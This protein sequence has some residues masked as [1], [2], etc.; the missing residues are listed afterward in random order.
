[1]PSEGATL[2]DGKIEVDNDDN[3]SDVESRDGS[4]KV[5]NNGS[6]SD[7]AEDPDISSDVDGLYDSAPPETPSKS[8]RKPT[9]KPTAKSTGEKVAKKEPTELVRL[10]HGISEGYDA[11]AINTARDS[12]VDLL[13]AIHQREVHI[14]VNNQDKLL[15]FSEADVISMANFFFFDMLGTPARK[16]F[17]QIIKQY[18]TLG[19]DGLDMGVAARAATLARD[20]ARLPQL[21]DFYTTF[22]RSQARHKALKTTSTYEMLMKQV[23]DVEMY[24]AYIALRELG[25]DNDVTLVEFLAAAGLTISKGRGHVSIINEYLCQEL[26]IAYDS[27]DFSNLCMSARSIAQMVDQWGYGILLFI[28]AK[29]STKSVSPCRP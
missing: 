18:T 12:F 3:G 5:S 8:P 13:L 6:D 25:R 15:S 29:S 24:N 10:T 16:R 2:F 17:Q 7:A 22:S 1:V 11:D 21:S 26:D 9:E 20:T 14:K 28:P 19:E 27:A 23:A 4:D